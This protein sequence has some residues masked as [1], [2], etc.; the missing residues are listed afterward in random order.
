MVAHSSS[1]GLGFERGSFQVRVE[2]NK[3]TRR[4][5]SL[6]GADEEQSGVKVGLFPLVFTWPYKTRKQLGEKGSRL[7]LGD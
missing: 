3:S 1:E 2:V 4:F 7:S 5:P 6:I